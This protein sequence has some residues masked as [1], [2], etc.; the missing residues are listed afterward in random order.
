MEAFNCNA[1]SFK[2]SPSFWIFLNY[3]KLVDIDANLVSYFGWI[4][5]AEEVFPIKSLIA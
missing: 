1:A 4:G 3:T 5:F 2:S